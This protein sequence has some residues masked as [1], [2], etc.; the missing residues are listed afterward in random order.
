MEQAIA[1]GT[2]DGRIQR[3]ERSQRVIIEAFLSLCEQG[4]LVPTAQQVA[5]EAG[6][7]IRTVFR[8]FSDMES[9]FIT[10]DKLLYQ[11]FQSLFE[12]KPEGSLEQRIEELVTS[13]ANGFE[14]VAPYVRS[15]LGQTWRYPR[16]ESN[17][18]KLCH[19]LRKQLLEGFPELKAVSKAVIA[20]AD[21]AVS[22]ECWNRLRLHSSRQASKTAMQL[23]LTSILVQ[24]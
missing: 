1:S 18:L 2:T 21:T 6:V 19:I 20:A 11:R 22:F 8:H 5:D 15:T 23:L 7:G 13:R 4:I 10:A 9:L 17:Y 24:S 3:S 14:A 12:F 16:L